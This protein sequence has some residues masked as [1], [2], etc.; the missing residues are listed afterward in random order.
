MILLLV[1]FS[2]ITLNATFAQSTPVKKQVAQKSILDLSDKVKEVSSEHFTENSL[3]ELKRFRELIKRYPKNANYYFAEGE[4]I[5]NL[6]MING[7]TY[8]PHNLQ[9]AQAIAKQGQILDYKSDRGWTLIG[10]IAIQ[11]NDLK[12]AIEAY[13]K[14]R[15]AN[16]KGYFTLMLSG[17]IA[18]KTGHLD[19]ALNDFKAAEL[20][21][22]STKRK[23]RSIDSEVRTKYAILFN[24]K[25]YQD[26]AKELVPDLERM[27]QIDPE[28]PWNLHNAATMYDAIG[29][30]SKTIELERKAL[31]KMN[32]GLARLTL[33]EAL[34]AKALN[35][36]GSSRGNGGN[37]EQAEKYVQE[38][39]RL[40]SDSSD[41]YVQFGVAQIA[42]FKAERNRD[43]STMDHIR[44]QIVLLKK[45]DPKY[46]LIKNIEDG[47]ERLD[48]LKS[49]RLPAN[50]DAQPNPSFPAASQRFQ[51]TF[52]VKE[53]G[54]YWG[55][56]VGQDH[57]SIVSAAKECQHDGQLIFVAI[58][59]LDHDGKIL[60]WVGQRDS[61]ENACMRSKLLGARFNP[62]PFTPFY[63]SIQFNL[64]AYNSRH[65]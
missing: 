61:E 65:K 41:V 34:V 42:V 23:T 57:E 19:E 18:K 60:N 33:R 31:S 1:T 62:P 37:I 36:A 47:L 13:Q 46:A 63:L 25:K 21:A 17:N 30:S 49:G 4:I 56:F 6:G 20:K 50:N 9:A 35:L 54:Q 15:E 10:R 55:T 7:D 48:R 14:A 29:N 39:A 26:F 2:F 11:Q 24:E 64:L 44:A 43:T 16:P 12:T 38:A 51:Q 52:R 5:M 45:L 3:E 32:F 59:Q 40:D 58:V 27:I 8:Q 28:D 22:P 53:G